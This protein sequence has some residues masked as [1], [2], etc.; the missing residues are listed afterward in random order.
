MTDAESGPP[1]QGGSIDPNALVQQVLRESY[2]QTTED[3]R[4]YAQKVR[5]FNSQKKIIRDY[6]RALREF[7]VGARSSAREAG[8]DP[9]SPDAGT[10]EIVA[11]AFE[12]RASA[13]T[14]DAVAR[15]LCIPDR[16]PPPGVM[17]VAALEN[18]IA[19]WEERLNSIGD[20]SQLA[21]V[22][23]QNLLQKQQQTLQMLSNISKLLH[24]TATAVIRKIG[25]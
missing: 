1:N 7:D 3:L 12:E 13:Y 25:G 10:A 4:Y 20:D 19:K 15:E 17:T 8:A 21:N 5:Y 18:E 22:D 14:L 11:K 16:V 9:C 6:L 23:L 2:L 24:D